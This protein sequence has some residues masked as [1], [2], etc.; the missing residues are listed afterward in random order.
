MSITSP[1]T[2]EDQDMQMLS[3]SHSEELRTT[4][5]SFPDPSVNATSPG[6]KT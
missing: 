6:D 5:V 2:R 1:P 4:V 3:W